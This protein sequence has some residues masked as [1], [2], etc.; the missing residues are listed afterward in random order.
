IRSEKEVFRGVD[1]GMDADEVKS[2]EKAAPAYEEPGAEL[3][4]SYQLNQADSF[5]V[6]YSFDEKG[7]YEI[8]C[9]IYIRNAETEVG[10]SLS[11][12]ILVH[13]TNHFGHPKEEHDGFKNWVFSNK[14]S[15]EIELSLQDVS[16]E[17]QYKLSISFYDFD[18]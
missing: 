5:T 16:D 7:L 13:F 6:S 8:L 2:A 9:V 18:Y 4:Y 1:I 17:Q 11:N 10:N 14:Y 12:D 3:F 15:D